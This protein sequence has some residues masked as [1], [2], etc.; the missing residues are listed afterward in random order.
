MYPES[1]TDGYKC[2]HKRQYP[3]FTSL[4]YSNLTPR[5]TRRNPA[6]DK[7]VFAGLQYFIKR[8]L[9]EGWQKDFFD[10]PKAQVVSRFTRLMRS[11][12]GPDNKV[13]FEHIAALHDLG[14]LPIKIAALPEG[15]LGSLRVPC[16]TIWNTHPDFFW[17]TNYL[18]TIL[19]TTLWGPC[20]SATTAR[21]YRKLFSQYAKETGGDLNFVPFQGHDF[22]FRGM[23]CFEAAQ[24]SGFGHAIYFAGT[25]T[26]PVLTFAEDYYGADLDTELVGCSVPA[27]EH[28]VMCAG[29]MVNEVETFRRLIEDIYPDGIVSIV[30]DTWDY[31]KVINPKEG[32][33]QTLKPKIMARNGKV[34]IRPDTG[35]PVK[36]VCGL[37]WEVK[38]LTE[39]SINEAL[40]ARFDYVMYNSVYYEI[41]FKANT[42]YLEPMDYDSVSPEI[43]GSIRCLWDGFG[44]KLNEKGFREL[45]SHVGLI[46]GDSITLERAG[47]ICERLKRAKFASTNIVFGIGSF[48]YAYVT[49]DTDGYAVKATFVR[50]KDQDYS[51]FKKPATGDGTKNS[52]KGLLSVT[53]LDG[54]F[55]LH[56]EVT[57]EEA[58]N[59]ELVVV[60]ENGVLLQEYTLKDIRQR[61]LEGI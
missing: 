27:T 51:I 56:E 18:E 16:L 29:G 8:Y 25:D 44:G 40:E 24:L 7:F 31:W 50:I 52:A 26:V 47:Q 55:V 32:I 5:T 58:T 11:Y 1:M 3:Q 14:Y 13:G 35:D 57:W 45:D 9:I 34:V 17:I 6:P 2:D 21:Q 10:L 41:K 43:K 23:F 15:S 39:A 37:A 61:A 36:I 48:T 49:R 54:T 53:K 4:V 19:S 60:F 20:T 30:S 28:S 38:D 46:Y 22:S 33:M 42:P 12:L 59:S